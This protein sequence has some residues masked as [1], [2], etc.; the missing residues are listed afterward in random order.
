MHPTPQERTKE[1]QNFRNAYFLGSSDFYGL[2][3]PCSLQFLFFLSG[4]RACAKKFEC[5][6]SKASKNKGPRLVT[7]L[8]AVSKLL[9][10][11]KV[12]G[13]PPR[14]PCGTGTGVGPLLVIISVR[15]S[16]CLWRGFETAFT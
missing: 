4:V 3:G 14:L 13:L 5:G 15:S 8:T 6:G 9:A 16:H 10:S 7:P 11:Q 12:G 1:G 2:R